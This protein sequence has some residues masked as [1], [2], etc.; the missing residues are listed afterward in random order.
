MIVRPVKKIGPIQK[1]HETRVS[2]FVKRKGSNALEKKNFKT[3][4]YAMQGGSNRRD[5]INEA[6]VGEEWHTTQAVVSAVISSSSSG[7]GTYRRRVLRSVIAAVCQVT[8]IASAVSASEGSKEREPMS[9]STATRSE[10]SL[11]V[12]DFTLEYSRIYQEFPYS[13]KS[14]E[15]RA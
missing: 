6:A 8:Q 10:I 15:Y 3:E 12:P 14:S 9:N 2:L 7:Q 13:S 5:S 1:N 4:L 11:L